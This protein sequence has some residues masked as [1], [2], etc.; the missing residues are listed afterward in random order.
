MAPITRNRAANTKALV[1]LASAAASIA[2]CSPSWQALAAERMAAD[3][4]S[5]AVKVCSEAQRTSAPGEN[6]RAAFFAG[7]F[8]VNCE[9]LDEAKEHFRFACTVDPANT[10]PVEAGA[11][12]GLAICHLRAAR[13]QVTLAAESWGH[14]SLD[15]LSA[16]CRRASESVTEADAALTMAAD[17]SSRAGEDQQALVFRLL[18]ARARRIRDNVNALG[19]I[20]VIVKVVGRGTASGESALSGLMQ[21]R[22]EAIGVAFEEYRGESPEKVGAPLPGVPGPLNSPST[23]P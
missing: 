18:R 23:R 19:E 10:P 6:Y 17:I 22:L 2:G 20:P 9:Q 16:A 5:G 11:W 21:S 7:I 15:E 8:A 3:D 12:N 13:K 14:D 1:L 4:C